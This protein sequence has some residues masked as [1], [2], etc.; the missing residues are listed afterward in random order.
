[1]NNFTD[2]PTSESEV[3]NK[4]LYPALVA[5][6]TLTGPLFS[7][8]T[9]LILISMIGSDNPMAIPYVCMLRCFIAIPSEYL[10]FMLN[11]NFYY[12]IGGLYMR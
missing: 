12:S 8:F 5:G 4:K 11:E 10:I 6:A 2:D 7:N 1:M 3:L 9:T